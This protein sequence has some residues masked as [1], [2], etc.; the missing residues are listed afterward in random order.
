MHTHT[1]AAILTHEPAY[2]HL[3]YTVYETL[4]FRLYH[5]DICYKLVIKS[6]EEI[7]KREWEGILKN[8]SKD[9]SASH[10][11]TDLWVS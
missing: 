1:R 2:R 6:C 7:K 5:M 9:F 11:Q 3:T 10:G 8:T 4:Y